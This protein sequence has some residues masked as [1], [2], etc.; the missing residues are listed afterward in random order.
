LVNEQMDVVCEIHIAAM[1]IR[2]ETR[3]LLAAHPARRWRCWSPPRFFRDGS[4]EIAP[5]EQ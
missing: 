1:G 4:L 2:P 3:R 5:G